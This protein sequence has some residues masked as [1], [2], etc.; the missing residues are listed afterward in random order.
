MSDSL[1]V[2]E[3]KKTSPY[4]DGSSDISRHADQFEEG[5]VPFGNYQEAIQRSVRTEL[6][7]QAKVQLT[8]YRRGL[9]HRAH[10][11]YNVGMIRCKRKKGK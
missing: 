7:Y 1:L 3:N 6:G 5:Y 8:I 11:F 2:W 4:Q 9:G 10:K